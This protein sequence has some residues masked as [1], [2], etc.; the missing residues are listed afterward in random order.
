MSAPGSQHHEEDSQEP[1]GEGGRG[2][3][4]IHSSAGGA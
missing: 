3:R 2:G 1:Y 4:S